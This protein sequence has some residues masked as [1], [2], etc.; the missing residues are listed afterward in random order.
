VMILNIQTDRQ[1]DRQIDGWE[2]WEDA[3]YT[4]SIL[5]ESYESSDVIRLSIYSRR[6]LRFWDWFRLLD[7]L[8]SSFLFKE[9]ALQLHNILRKDNN[10]RLDRQVITTKIGI[11]G[12]LLLSNH[13]SLDYDSDIHPRESQRWRRMMLYEKRSTVILVKPPNPLTH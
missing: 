5:W 4:K 1:T 10:L 9:S 13:Y 11:T 3:W 7:H 8:L 6:Y 12:H 2:W